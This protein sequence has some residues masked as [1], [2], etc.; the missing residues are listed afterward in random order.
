[1]TCRKDLLPW[2][3]PDSSLL[4]VVPLLPCRGLHRAG[5]KECGWN[6]VSSQALDNPRDYLHSGGGDRKR[7]EMDSSKPLGQS[8]LGTDNVQVFTKWTACPAGFECR[9]AAMAVCPH[10]RPPPSTRGIG[11]GSGKGSDETLPTSSIFLHLPAIGLMP[12][13]VDFSIAFLF[14]SPSI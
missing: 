13:R 14:F 7:P 5:L 10:Q 8:W 2:C 6:W 1:M 9:E 11:T 3:S 12:W 4:S